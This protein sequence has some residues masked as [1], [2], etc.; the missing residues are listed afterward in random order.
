MT[1]VSG[2][3]AAGPS[4]GALITIDR[5]TVWAALTTLLFTVGSG[6]AISQLPA[7]GSIASAV[8]AM[9]NLVYVLTIPVFDI[10][11]RLF[12]R[13]QVQRFHTEPVEGSRNLFFVVFISALLMFAVT[14]IVSYLVG[15]GV[16]Y[17]CRGVSAAASQIRVGDCFAFGLGTMSTTVT[18][19]VM[20]ALGLACGWIWQR[21]VPGRLWF[22]LA[23]VVPL[24]LLMFA[25]DYLYAMGTM[26]EEI[27]Q[28]IMEQVRSGGA[29]LQIGKQVVIL[30][31]PLL[32]GYAVAASWS[33][34]ARRLV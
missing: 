22:A 9:K 17:M 28:P 30:T 7:S 1:D 27:L 18:L 31:L 15:F 34:L 11:R 2:G 24:L 13:R 16:G 6:V 3:V 26:N 19:P 8:D 20:L 29:G 5:A 10:A 4:P 33:A 14:E 23:M 32:L 25:L 12:L 21:L